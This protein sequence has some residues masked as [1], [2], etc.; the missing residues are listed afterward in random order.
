M[1]KF[2]RATKKN[3]N[4]WGEIP[5]SRIEVFDIIDIVPKLNYKFFVISLS[6]TTGIFKNFEQDGCKNQ[7]E[8]LRNNS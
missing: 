2:L 5:L 1:K 6:I 8:N 7:K 3:L 4:K